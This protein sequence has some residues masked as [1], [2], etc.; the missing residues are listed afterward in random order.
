[1]NFLN[2][3]KK[4]KVKVKYLKVHWSLHKYVS[5]FFC[6]I[7]YTNLKEG[8]GMKENLGSL[9]NKPSNAWKPWV[10]E[11]QT[12]LEPPE[13]QQRQERILCCEDL[14]GLEHHQL[15]SLLSN[16]CVVLCFCC[17]FVLTTVLESYSSHWPKFCLAI[18]LFLAPN[19]TLLRSLLFNS[20]L[21]TLQTPLSP[22][23]TPRLLPSLSQTYPVFTTVPCKIF[24]HSLASLLPTNFSS[25]RDMLFLQ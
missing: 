17:W 23:Y 8:L 14:W 21:G 5:L 13:T 16:L 19:L 18:T 24:L 11:T 9:G 2:S 12:W 15:D 7:L 20:L 4:K 10:W 25:P 22:S 3:Q 6:F 1:M